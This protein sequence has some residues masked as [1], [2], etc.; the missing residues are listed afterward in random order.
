MDKAR[1]RRIR[2]LRPQVESLEVKQVMSLSAGASAVGTLEVLRH[3]AALK[4]MPTMTPHRAVH[5]A[6]Q[7]IRHRHGHHHRVHLTLP[8]TPIANPNPNPHPAPIPNPSPI[9]PPSP[10]PAPSPNPSPMPIAIPSPNYPPFVSPGT[11]PSSPLKVVLTTDKNTYQVGQPVQVTI[12]ET[13]TSNQDAKVL[14]GCQILQG[15]VTRN[16]V[17][18]WHYVDQ[19]ECATFQTVLHAHQSRQL[20]L[21]WNGVFSSPGAQS[22]PRTGTFVFHAGVDGVNGTATFTIA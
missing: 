21:E 3:M 20:S 10:I 13:N 19:R 18:V 17:E 5:H 14:V 16:G 6:V 1:V 9:L 12:T 8:S 15:S 2:G 7:V 4:S 22:L 11:D